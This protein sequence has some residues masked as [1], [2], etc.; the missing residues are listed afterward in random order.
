MAKLLLVSN[1]VPWTVACAGGKGVLKPSSGGL[2]TALAGTHARGET[3]WVGW[4]GDLGGLD[5]E[6]R[7]A[8]LDELQAQRVIPVELSAEEVE[9]YYEGFSNGVLWPLFHYLLD[10]VR[11]DTDQDWDAYASV[12]QR[13]AEAAA[14]RAEPGD[15]VWIHDYQLML[16]PRYLREL[17]PDLR[18]GFFLHIPFPA[19]EVFRILPWRELLLQ[20]VLASDLVG[21]H[22]PG[23]QA[24]FVN[25]SRR[26]LGAESR[27]DGL[28]Y[29]GHHVALGDYAIGI[30]AEAFSTTAASPSVMARVQEI[31]QDLGGRTLILG[32][33][34]LDYT[35]GIPQRLLAVE[36]Y[37]ELH[38]EMRD[39]VLFLQ[40]SVP[41]RERVEAY[42]QY[43]KQVDEV[44]GRINGLYGSPSR[45]PVHVLHRNIPF[46]E[47]VA[48]YR[49]ADVM[50]VTPLRDGMNLVAK[51]FCATRGDDSGILILSEFAGAS[52]DLREAI[53]V[54]PYDTGAMAEALDTALR[55]PPG[56][57]RARMRALRKRVIT[58]DVHRWAEA[59]L[60]DLHA[61]GP[62][63]HPMAAHEAFLP[64]LL[65]DASDT[66]R[67]A[68]LLDYDGTLVPFTERPEEAVP[69]PDLLALLERL[70][71][72]EGNELHLVSGRG[73]DVLDAWF[74]GG[75]FILHAEHGLWRKAGP[76]SPW[77]ARMDHSPGWK[78]EAKTVL[79]GWARN[80]EGALL[81]EK[82][83]SIA[84]HYRQVR[85]GVS[86]QTLQ[87]IRDSLRPLAEREGLEVLEGSKVLELRLR[88]AH[89]GLAVDEALTTQG[90]LVVALGDDRTDEDL[91]RA[92]PPSAL[93]I[94]VGQG[95]SRALTRLPDP[96]AVRRFLEDLAA[97]LERIPRKALV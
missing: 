43:R 59:F 31:R 8:I 58:H 39:S 34:R 74:G 37:L 93:S 19:Y 26:I 88:G 87:A 1:R 16:V 29:D 92:L 90:T 28:D 38:P 60:R 67:I 54:N 78:L 14:E 79:E 89:K 35:K 62:S 10:K 83:H 68:L 22:T 52:A 61:Q 76:G 5:A 66:E 55:M 85:R 64:S 82:D 7:Q 94:R 63:P 30:D 24:H 41:S 32:V 23:Y 91:F 3:L 72:I 18:I 69:D 36:R 86:S 73:K 57:A 51:E 4:P 53:L 81:E 20:G 44:T 46:E 12:N 13:F 42:A 11:L 77:T 47:L 50:L 65:E 95:P 84:W 17:R 97:G 45:V 71:R 96:R 6:A 75:P 48:L 33:D 70:A 40:A 2:A 25:A 49:A 80:F 15:S 9:R 27:E 56:Q 21:F